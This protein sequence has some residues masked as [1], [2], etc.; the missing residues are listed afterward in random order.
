MNKLTMALFALPWMAAAAT[1]PEITAPVQV[2]VTVEGPHGGSIASLHREDF[3]VMQGNEK[4]SVTSAVPLQG[5]DASLELWVLID[6]ASHWTLGSELGDLRTFINAQSPATAVGVGYMRNGTVFPAEHLTKD[7]ARAAKSL[8]LPMG[9]GGSPYLSLSDLIGRWPATTARREVIMVTSGADPLGGPGPMNPYLEAAVG[10]A[11]RAGIIVY[12]IYSPG[13]GH[14]AHSF[15][16]LNWGQN[17]LGQLSDQ[18]GG[19]AYM[20][21]FDTPVSIMPYLNEIAEHLAHQ[22]RLTFLADASGKPGLKTIRVTTEVP[23]AEIVAPD[24]VPVPVVR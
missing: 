23:H 8:R 2:V 9:T 15:W 4:R 22:Y 7:H 21:G 3:I 20:L 24:R 11:Q 12:G 18:T 6:D 10:D 16:R 17:D 13:I 14:S 1:G 5:S 19:E